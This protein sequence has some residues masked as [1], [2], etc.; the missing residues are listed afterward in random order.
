MNPLLKSVL[1]SREKLKKVEF[2][3]EHPECFDE[4]MSIALTDEKPFG[5]RATWMIGGYMKKNDPRITPYIS[6]IIDVLPELE[7]GHQREFIK[8][9]LKM[10]MEEE[11]ESRLYDYSTTLWE[12]VQKKPSVRHFAFQCMIRFAEK[13]PELNHEILVLAQP[14]YVNAL[15][16]GIRKSILKAIRKIEESQ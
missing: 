6:E 7:D 9:L 16:P 15:S 1:L 13:Y 14:H 3:D 11:Q 4:A 8:I 10:D 12:Q 5:W 2:L